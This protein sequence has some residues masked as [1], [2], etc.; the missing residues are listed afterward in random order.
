MDILHRL[1]IYLL[2]PA[3]YGLMLIASCLEV[4][5]E[6]MTE[7]KNWNFK[8]SLDDKE[9]GS[10][11]FSLAKENER[12]VINIAADFEIKVLFFKAFG[13]EHRNTEIWAD[14]CLQNIQSKTDANG[15]DFWLQ[16]EKQSDHFLV[17][18]KRP[19][20]DEENAKLPTCIMSFAYWDSAIV[21]QTQ[22]LNAQDGEYLDVD[23][24]P[25][26]QEQI[27]VKEQN[28][29]ASRYQIKG[30]KELKIDLWYSDRGDWLRL[31]SAVPDRDAKL[32][33]ELY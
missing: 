6:A 10:H 16:G 33:Y 30:E 27:I 5:A 21:Q 13:Y 8:V 28:V 15:K 18:R 17:K 19:K 29:D 4:Q 7:V 26:G 11:T 23:I 22:L 1:V 2:V 31:E 12:E 24:Q 25:M 20:E 32:I 3:L 9:I 14:G